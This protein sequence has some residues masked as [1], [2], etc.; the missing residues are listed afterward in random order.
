[1]VVPKGLRSLISKFI[2]LYEESKMTTMVVDR[3]M[4]YGDTLITHNGAVQGTASKYFTVR[5]KY[6]IAVVGDQS[7]LT[8]AML[9]IH[10][11]LEFSSNRS[12]LSVFRHVETNAIVFD[13]DNN[14]RICHL[15]ELLKDVMDDNSILLLISTDSVYEFA[16]GEDG[17][18][19]AYKPP[20]PAY[21]GSGGKYIKA[22]MKYSL[23]GCTEKPIDM[24]TANLTHMAKVIASI[25]TKTNDMWD[26][27]KLPNN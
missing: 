17:R 18:V 27:I 15:L 3:G 16:R 25:D 7:V 4:Y 13:E 6:I 22:L 26:F 8:T 12:D 5:D 20:L 24:K 9:K 11:A 21:Y 19:R 10:E 2:F 23:R 14:I 1:M